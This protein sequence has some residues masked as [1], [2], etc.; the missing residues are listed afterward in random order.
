MPDRVDYSEFYDRIH[1]LIETKAQGTLFTKCDKN[2]L[3]IVA[4]RDG[5]IISLRYGPKRGEAAIPL[6]RAIKFG[7]IRLDGR[8]ITDGCNPSSAPAT[9]RVPGKNAGHWR[10]I[11][12]RGAGIRAGCE[13]R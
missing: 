8:A 3:I 5:K 1:D 4:V 9:R 13:T 6:I 2:H 11:P 10:L 12:G 7:D